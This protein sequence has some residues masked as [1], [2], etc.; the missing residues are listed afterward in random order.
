MDCCNEQQFENVP[1]TEIQ[2]RPALI[3]GTSGDTV[4]GNFWGLLA[5]I[6][7]WDCV[8]RLS[9]SWMECIDSIGPAI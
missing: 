5:H 1:Y 2:F 4:Y 6:N 7:S 8:H 9:P 3:S